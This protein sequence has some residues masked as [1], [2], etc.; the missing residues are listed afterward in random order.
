MLQYYYELF[1]SDSFDLENLADFKVL[2]ESVNAA[3]Q[4]Q[5][6]SFLQQTDDDNED[7]DH[8]SGRIMN[9]YTGILSNLVLT[10]D[11]YTSSSTLKLVEAVGYILSLLSLSLCTSH[12]KKHVSDIYDRLMI[13]KS[14]SFNELRALLGTFVSKSSEKIAIEDMRGLFRKHFLDNEA[15]HH[16]E[17]P[18]QALTLLLQ[19]ISIH[20]TGYLSYVPPS[21]PPALVLPIEV[22]I[23]I[24]KKSILS[25]MM[26]ENGQSIPYF[27]FL[28]SVEMVLCSD[29]VFIYVLSR[30][31]CV[32][33]SEE[34]RRI[35]KASD[36]FYQLLQSTYLFVNTI[37]VP[38]H[39]ILSF[40]SNDWTEELSQG[41]LNA[42][43]TTDSVIPSTVGKTGINSTSFG[44]TGSDAS[45]TSLNEKNIFNRRYFRRF[46]LTVVERCPSLELAAS[47]NRECDTKIAF[48]STSYILQSISEDGRSTRAEL[49][50]YLR[51]ALVDSQ[52]KVIELLAYY[53]A[54]I[55]DLASSKLSL[56]QSSTYKLFES[57]VSSIVN[58]TEHI[59]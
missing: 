28:Q 25:N 18:F 53:S 22:V 59:M 58:Q 33:Q 5:R 55:E 47:L 46:P 57:I 32:I 50:H 51:T 1:N 34:S 12:R 45:N 9:Q 43:V 26:N 13:S 54:Y 37:K 30:V 7:E 20:S 38:I 27:Q 41:R 52:W 23:S 10:V 31:F 35:S 44:F 29:A 3:R 36:R 6:Q 14:L 56:H 48:L 21:I 11:Q 8:D 17:D 42:S 15:P 4:L 2:H 40:L 49:E 24:V 16:H 39:C 19:L